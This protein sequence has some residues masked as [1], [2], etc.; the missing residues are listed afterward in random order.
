MPPTGTYRGPF[1]FSGIHPLST[2]CVR[3]GVKT[4]GDVD[5]VVQRAASSSKALGVGWWAPNPF[6]LSCME[7]LC[8]VVE[9][10]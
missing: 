5:G 8:G 4:P 9:G 7:A 10:V 6:V 3:G 1:A 2:S